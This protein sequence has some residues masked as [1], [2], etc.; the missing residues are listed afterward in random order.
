LY[1]PRTRRTAVSWGFCRC[2]NRRRRYA[3]CWPALPRGDGGGDGAEGA[4]GLIG[5]AQHDPALRHALL[6]QFIERGWY[7]WAGVGEVG[8]AGAEDPVVHAGEEAGRAQPGVCD[9]VQ[10][11]ADLAAGHLRGRFPEQGRE[12]VAQVGVGEAVEQ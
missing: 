4:A 12:V 9:L 11:V 7:R 3:G 6:D 1:R 5:E 8:H 10:V 2:A